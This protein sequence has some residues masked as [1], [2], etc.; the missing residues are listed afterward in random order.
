[1]FIFIFQTI[2]A[3][4][5]DILLSK[6]LGRNKP[7]NTGTS[8]FLYFDNWAFLKL[9]IEKQSTLPQFLGHRQQILQLSCL[10]QRLTMVLLEYMYDC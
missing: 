9:G 5:V 1:M 7:V 8:L 2:S 10:F 3:D 6:T 4:L